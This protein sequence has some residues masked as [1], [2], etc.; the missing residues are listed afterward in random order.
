MELTKWSFLLRRETPSAGGNAF[1]QFVPCKCGPFSF[2]LHHEANS[3]ASRGLLE[4]PDQNTWRSPSNSLSRATQLPGHIITDARSIVDRFGSEPVRRLL[5]HVYRH[6]PWFSI[7]STRKRLAQ[8]PQA[9]PAVYTAGYQGMTV[10]G[11]LDM[12]LRH[13]IRRVIDVRCNPV[14]RRFGFHKGTLNRLCA[15]LDIAYLHVGELGVPSRWRRDLDTDNDYQQLLTRYDTE[16]LAR[17]PAAIDRVAELIQEATSA[18]LCMEADPSRCHR[19]RLAGTLA[20]RTGLTV[21]HVEFTE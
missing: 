20:E 9:Q 14:A 21:K 12:L 1:Y 16:I 19:S 18:L 15:A 3:L 13:G 8:R 7:N 10:D 4:T 2:C 11:F 17:E 6:Y 5:D